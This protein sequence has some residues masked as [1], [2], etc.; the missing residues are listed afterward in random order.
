MRYGRRMCRYLRSQPAEYG[1][2]RLGSYLAW[3]GWVYLAFTLLLLLKRERRMRSPGAP[4]HVQ[5]YLRSAH[6]H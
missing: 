6:H 4:V 3:W 5:I 1:L 2:L